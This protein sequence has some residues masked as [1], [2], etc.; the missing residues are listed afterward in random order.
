MKDL[1]ILDDA[2]SNKRF[3]FKGEGGEYFGIWIVNALLT[4]ITLGIY[5]AWAKTKERHFLHSNTYLANSPFAYHGTG[6]ELFIG[7]IKAIGIFVIPYLI[8][9]GISTTQNST[10]IIFTGLIFLLYILI[11]IPFA[12]HGSLRYQ[13]SRTSWRGIYLG[14]N[15][16]RTE[17]VKLFL[18]NI[19]LTIITFGFYSSW[20]SVNIRKYITDHVNFGNVTAT[21]KGKGN[22]LFVI[23]L[24]GTILT[25]L[26]LG[27]YSFWYFRNIIN[28]YI[29]NTELEQDGRTISV[30]S[31]V[32]AGGIFGLVIVNVLLI[33]FTLG[34]ATPWVVIRTIRFYMDN[35]I[36]DNNFK[37]SEIRQGAIDVSA[38]A[39]GD[40]VLDILIS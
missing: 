19:L 2:G 37:P 10:L 12:I 13:T 32:T 39:T 31:T 21:F 36:L 14:Y 33:I 25:F 34:L 17:F 18:K 8:V 30:Q 23:S 27:I 35:V 40:D 1:E 24:V 7:F 4:A 6:K 11:I 28:F 38:D 29:T 20:A 26:T 5:Y 3:E 9:I 22:D 15:G 16:D